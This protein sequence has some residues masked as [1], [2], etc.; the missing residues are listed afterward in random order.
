M[1]LGVAKDAPRTVNERGGGQTAAAYGFDC[2]DPQAMF[3]MTQALEE[4]RQ[5]YGKDNW[6]LI[7]IEDHLNHLLIHIFAYMAGDTQDDHLG[8]AM[9]RAM[10]AKAVATENQERMKPINA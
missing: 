7:P 5:T 6:R 8:H 2:L 10:F 4:G 3:A 9:C 1:I